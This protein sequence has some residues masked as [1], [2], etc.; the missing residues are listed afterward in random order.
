MTKFSDWVEKNA[1]KIVFTAII[2]V[3]VFLNGLVIYRIQNEINTLETAFIKAQKDNLIVK[4]NKPTYSELKSH[5]VFIIGCS[6]KKLAK[7]KITSPIN[8]EDDGMCW[9]GTGVIIKITETETY[10][11]TNNHVVGK[12][13]ND[14]I[15]YVENGQQNIQATLVKYHS[16]V[17]AAVIKIESKLEGK[18]PILRIATPNIQDPVYMVGH[19]LGV[20]NVYSEGVVAGVED[21]SMLLQLPCIYGNSG[22]GIFDKDGNLVGLIYALETYRGFIGI[23]EARITHA[24]AV[25]SIDIKIFLTEL[26]LYNEN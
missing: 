14:V 8:I 22:S 5:T 6:G 13:E 7:N 21:N 11:L 25:D 24:L 3:S 18:S 26:E 20:R 2:I 17:D 16:Y 12:E 15:L 10:I 1:L 4:K 9:S 19:P 23:P